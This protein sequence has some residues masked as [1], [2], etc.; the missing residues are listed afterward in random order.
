MPEL[1]TVCPF[2]IISKTNKTLRRVTLCFFRFT[3]G[4]PC[5][6]LSVG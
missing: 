4:S 2:L 6:F 3:G 1:F 5:C